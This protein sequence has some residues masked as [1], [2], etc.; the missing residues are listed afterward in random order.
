MFTDRLSEGQLFRNLTSLDGKPCA[1]LSVTV[2]F[3]GWDY[4]LKIGTEQPAW[5]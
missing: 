3:D 2:S 4:N 1:D 5:K